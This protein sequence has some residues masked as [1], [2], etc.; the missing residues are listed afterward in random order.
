ME[1]KP[2]R[3]EHDSRV[4]SAAA[5]VAEHQRFL[6]LVHADDDEAWQASKQRCGGQ[7]ARGNSQSDG[8]KALTYKSNAQMIVK[9][10]QQLHD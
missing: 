3:A 9:I 6:V 10:L 2:W 4:R 7:D 5:P 1:W 8:S